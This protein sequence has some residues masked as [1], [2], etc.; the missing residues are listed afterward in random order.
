MLWPP[1]KG[2]A[3]GVTIPGSPRGDPD[4]ILVH[5]AAPGR[6][7][8]PRVMGGG[9]LTRG[10]PAAS[11]LAAFGCCKQK[12]KIKT[13]KREG[14]KKKRGKA[15]GWPAAPPAPPGRTPLRRRS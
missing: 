3:M 15:K 11:R 8:S 9:G 13:L 5:P 7:G 1:R 14:K 2:S 12:T 6:L 10:G 4:R